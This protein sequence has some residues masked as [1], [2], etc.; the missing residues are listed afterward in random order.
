MIRINTLVVVLLVVCIAACGGEKVGA[1]SPATRGGD[2]QPVQATAPAESNDRTASM[3]GGHAGQTE[4]I[5]IPREYVLGRSTVVLEGESWRE[6]LDKLPVS[7]REMLQDRNAAYFGSLEFSDAE[8][9]KTMARQG[10]PLPEDWIDAS[11]MS[12]DE[13]KRMAE[14]GST[15]A[16]MLYADRMIDEAIGHLPVRQRDPGAYDHGP[17]GA[18]AIQAYIEV[19]RLVDSTSSPFASYVGGR[20]RY[21]L[22]VPASREAIAGAMFAASQRGDARAAAMLERFVADNPGMDVGSIVAAYQALKAK[23]D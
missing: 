3:D 6:L 17:G 21:S 18:A 2:G 10:F 16:R 11:T 8:E 19:G 4:S 9:W 20:L 12:S 5:T 1:V 23:G 22:D 7:Q 15:K 14:R 13:L